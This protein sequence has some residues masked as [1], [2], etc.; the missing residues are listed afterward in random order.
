[1]TLRVLKIVFPSIV[2]ILSFI[3]L[4]LHIK[5]TENRIIILKDANIMLLALTLILVYL[6]GFTRQ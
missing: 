5:K 6:D 3:S 1:M 2:F 4:L